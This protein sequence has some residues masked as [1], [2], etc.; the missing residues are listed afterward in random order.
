MSPFKPINRH[1]NIYL[2]PP[3]VD[4]WLPEQHLAR[5]VVDVV[6]QLDLKEMERALPG[7]GDRGLSSGFVAVDPDLRLCHRRVREPQTGTGDL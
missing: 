2:F 6:E 4:D 1:T 7:S 5:F 3:S